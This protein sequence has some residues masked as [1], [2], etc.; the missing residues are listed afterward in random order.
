MG[1][2]GWT[3]GRPVVADYSTTD[4]N[5][6]HFA[7][8]QHPI[9]AIIAELRA[10]LD[11]A[12]ATE[13]D[14]SLGCQRVDRWQAFATLAHRNQAPAF[15]LLLERIRQHGKG[16]AH[17]DFAL[18]E[19]LCT[20]AMSIEPNDEE[21]ITILAA[22]YIDRGLH[23]QAMTMLQ[24]LRAQGSES[25]IIDRLLGQACWRA[26]DS[27]GAAAA[28]YRIAADAT[29]HD[30]ESLKLAAEYF[31]FEGSRPSL[32]M[33]LFRMTE[34]RDDDPE[35][36]LWRAEWHIEDLDRDQGLQ[37][38]DKAVARAEPAS[39]LYWRIWRARFDFEHPDDAETYK[40][41]TAGIFHVPPGESVSGLE[42]LVR[43]H[44]D[45]WEA[46]YFLGTCYRRMGRLADAETC[47]RAT[48]GFL[49]YPNAWLELGGVLGE[50][51]RTREA[52]EASTRAN[53]HFEGR[54]HVPLCNLAAAHI[55]LKDWESAAA[56]L[57]KAKAA[58]PQS[59]A[60]KRLEAE[61]AMRR[62][63]RPWWRRMF[64]R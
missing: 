53:K 22:R 49:D 32:R 23:P 40:G 34:I 39:S 7:M 12:I 19:L 27:D 48:V 5:L 31:R 28:F 8:S 30:W 47:F 41:L 1:C 38:L 2:G 45:F 29:K 58:R 50:L 55:E 37:W 21:V 54:N 15:G 13:T 59:P 17:S 44:P 33:L 61:L 57:D 26:G 56:W 42:A 20:K 16:P 63:H 6:P 36:C 3:S 11:A 64:G 24:D 46:H 62:S 43:K 25:P 51:G 52:I 35:V 18:A 9:D 14:A 60:V 4:T 10:A